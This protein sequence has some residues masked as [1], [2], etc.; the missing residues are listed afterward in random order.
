MLKKRPLPLLVLLAA[1]TIATAQEA[2]QR[3]APAAPIDLG[4]GLGYELS[5]QT[6]LSDGNTPLWLN[7]N[8]YGLSSLDEA[9]GYLRMAVE[10]SVERDSMRRW[11]VGYG[12][13][14]AVASGYTSKLVVQQAY[15]E[16][17]WLHGTL[18]VG[19]REWPAEM[20]N[21]TLSSGA[22]T[23]GINARP[24]PQVRLALPDYWAIPRLGGR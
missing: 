10:R 3:E 18:T 6:S 13:D 14:V 22:Q 2:W 19:S 9:N 23:L 15:G 1:P 21:A 20:K 24:V 16:L 5:M 4:A 12:I 8:H 11:G 7:A 17:R